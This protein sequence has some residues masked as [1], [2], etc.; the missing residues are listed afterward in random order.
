[1]L[2]LDCPY[3]FTHLEIRWGLP[4]LNAIGVPTTSF[5]GEEVDR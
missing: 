2:L 4:P 1:M 3:V 5:T